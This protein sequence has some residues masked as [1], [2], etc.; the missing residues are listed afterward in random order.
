MEPLAVVYGRDIEP[1]RQASHQRPAFLIDAPHHFAFHP[2]I[3]HLE[4]SRHLTRGSWELPWAQVQPSAQERHSCEVID[5]PRCFRNLQDSEAALLPG[6]VRYISMLSGRTGESDFV[7]AL[8]IERPL[9]FLIIYPAETNMSSGVGHLT[10][11]GSLGPMFVGAYQTVTEECFLK[12]LRNR[13]G[14][15]LLVSCPAMRD[16]TL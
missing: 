8:L 13:S 3:L 7:K 15:H 5:A 14:P 2:L 4:R 16:T 9:R 10:I 1:E 6:D 12:Y 11:S